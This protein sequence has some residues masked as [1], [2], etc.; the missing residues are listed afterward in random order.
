MESFEGFS[1]RRHQVCNQ[2]WDRCGI[3]CAAIVPRIDSTILSTLA[4]RMGTFVVYVGMLDD[5]RC[6][7]HHGLCPLWRNMSGGYLCDSIMAYNSR[8]S[9]RFGLCGLA[10]VVLDSIH[11]RGT[12]KGS[13]GTFHHAYVQSLGSLRVLIVGER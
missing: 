9:L 1:T 13:H 7:K 3:V 5:H 4:W 2:S 6:I 11:N 10:H 8:Q 12:R